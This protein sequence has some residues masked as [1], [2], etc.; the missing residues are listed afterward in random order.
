VI[1]H[2]ADNLAIIKCRALNTTS[3][4]YNLVTIGDRPDSKGFVFNATFSGYVFV[5]VGL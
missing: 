5:A 1:S 3:L 2:I 4:F